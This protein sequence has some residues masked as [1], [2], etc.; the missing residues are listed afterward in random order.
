M[1]GVATSVHPSKLID[2]ILR[3]KLRIRS[4]GGSNGGFPI[5][6]CPSRF[7]L[8]CPVLDVP[9]VSDCL[10]FRDRP[11]C[12]CAL[13]SA[14]EKNLQGTFLKQSQDTIRTFQT[15]WDAFV[16]KPHVCLLS[17]TILAE[18]SQITTSLRFG[19]T[20]RKQDTQKFY[21]LAINTC[22]ATCWQFA[23]FPLKAQS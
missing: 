19:A 2:V 7:V 11:V 5:W 14:Y 6:A 9:D 18:R 3:C 10:I 17:T 12:P 21:D 15:K 4:R 16:G 1:S 13:I 22:N 8:F 20:V 23:V